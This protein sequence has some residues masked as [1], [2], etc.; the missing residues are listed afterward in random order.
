MRS[1]RAETDGLGVHYKGQKDPLGHRGVCDRRWDRL[2]L[3]WDVNE[4][5]FKE[6]LF[7]KE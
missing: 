6:V 7:R 5:L 3:H 2:N 1:L 4:L